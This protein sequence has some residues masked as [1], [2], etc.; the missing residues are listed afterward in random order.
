[1]LE[2]IRFLLL[3][4]LLITVTPR[5]NAQTH[6]ETTGDIAVNVDPASASLT[7]GRRGIRTLNITSAPAAVRKLGKSCSANLFFSREFDPNPDKYPIAFSYLN[8]KN[9]LGGSFFGGGLFSHD[10]KG[11]A[12]FLELGEQVRVR[13][14]FTTYDKSEGKDGRRV[15]TVKGE[16][17]CSRGDV[18]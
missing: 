15:V 9:T 7:M 4:C 3:A 13:F 10:S 18:F 16:A 14:E 1:M 17:V 11:E 2:G 5:S 8:K 6:F 12:E